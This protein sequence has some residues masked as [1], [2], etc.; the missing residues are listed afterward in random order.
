MIV[1]ILQ[2]MAFPFG[3]REAQPEGENP[4]REGLAKGNQGITRVDEGDRAQQR[5]QPADG[6]HDHAEAAG[7]RRREVKPQ[8]KAKAGKPAAKAK[9]AAKSAKA[10]PKKAPA[11]KP[12]AKPA[13]KA[14]KAPA[15]RAPAKK[16]PAKKPAA[17]A[18]KPKP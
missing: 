16:P 1:S 17:K 7:A 15:K 5:G 3:R 2:L 18:A 12:A 8:P 9:P 10:A 13:K 6:R 11:K 4:H 14:A